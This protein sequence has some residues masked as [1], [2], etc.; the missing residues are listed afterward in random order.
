[1]RFLAALSFLTIIPLPLRREIDPEEVGRSIAYFPVVGVIIGLI[2]AGLNWLFGLFLPSAVVNG[3]LIVAMVLD[4]AEGKVSAMLVNSTV[5][6]GRLLVKM[7][8]LNMKYGRPANA[9]RAQQGP[10]INLL[11]GQAE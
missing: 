4:A 7:A 11:T 8:E 3:R 1:M 10:T 6:A 5:N 2:L 9:K